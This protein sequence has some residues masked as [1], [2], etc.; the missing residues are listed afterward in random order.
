MDHDR[1]LLEFEAGRIEPEQVYHL[2]A[3]SRTTETDWQY[4]KSNN[5]E[6]SQRIWTACVRQKT[7]LFYA[8]SAATYGD[9]SAGFDDQGDLTGLKPLNLYGRSKHEFDLWALQEVAANR[10]PAQ[11]V[12]YKFFN[13]FGPGE[14]HK[15]RMASMVYHGFH[16]VQAGGEIRLFESY[17]PGIPHG[18]QTRDFIYV[19]D[20]IRVMLDLTAKPNICGLFNLGTGKARSFNDLAR[21]I[22]AALQRPPQIEYISMPSDLRNAYQYHTEATMRKMEACGINVK[23]RSLEDSVADYICAHPNSMERVAQ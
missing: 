20:V 14:A 13:V 10:K 7:R 3:C 4:L 23:F 17:R 11:W 6:Y 16:Q 15:G 5:L 1:F 2:G 8:S 19:K 12:G 21:S 9:G 22:F 18:G